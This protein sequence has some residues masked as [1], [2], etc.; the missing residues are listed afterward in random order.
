MQQLQRINPILLSCCCKQALIHYY[1]KFGY[2]LL[3]LSASQHG[4]AVWYDML[5]EF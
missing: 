4:G 3:G 5:L 2:R 1:E